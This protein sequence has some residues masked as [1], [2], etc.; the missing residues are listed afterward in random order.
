ML[1]I[2]G[3]FLPR[4]MSVSGYRDGLL[5]LR[6]R[7]YGKGTKILSQIPEG[8]ELE[9]MGPLGNGYPEPDTNKKVLLV[10]G[11]MGFA[12]LVYLYDDFVRKGFEPVFLYG[13]SEQAN[14]CINYPFLK[15]A[16]LD[17]SKGYGGDVIEL[18]RIY[19]E[20]N[21]G[22]YHIFSCGPLV[23]YR[24]LQKHVKPSNSY[25]VSLE[26][27]MA[28]GIGACLACV[29]PVAGGKRIC[30][31]GPVFPLNQVFPESLMKDK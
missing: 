14:L 15:I 19:I 13:E 29:S 21:P 25:H 18:M 6:I 22:D 9:I 30:L 27:H 12:P 8:T 31:D 5:T 16:T 3:V 11:G 4:P 28:C 10:A 17:G 26:E 2:E 24:S 23:M 7:E 20:D 1:R